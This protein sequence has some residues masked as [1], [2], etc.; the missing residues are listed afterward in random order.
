MVP[1]TWIEVKKGDFRSPFLIL[2]IKLKSA[3]I[4]EYKEHMENKN[5]GYIT[6]LFMAND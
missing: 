2:H 6:S 5:Q 1:L 3:V 4:Y